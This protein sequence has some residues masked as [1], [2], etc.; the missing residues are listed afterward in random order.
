[1][2]QKT[3]DFKYRITNN[4]EINNLF[5]IELI[6]AYSK[7]N[8]S[9]EYKLEEYVCALIT[10]QINDS[11]NLNILLKTATIDSLNEPRNYWIIKKAFEI[12]A[13]D[14]KETSLK[15]LVAYNLNRVY[16]RAHLDPKGTT[17]ER[18][19]PT[20]GS[21]LQNF[22]LALRDYIPQS[23]FLWFYLQYSLQPIASTDWLAL[24]DTYNLE[25]IKEVRE[26]IFPHFVQEWLHFT[27]E[28]VL[29]C[30]E[31]AK[32]NY[33]NALAACGKLFALHEKGKEIPKQE[34]YLA[35]GFFNHI[36]GQL[37]SR[38]K[39]DKSP[40]HMA[41]LEL[42]QGN[43]EKVIKIL[44]PVVSNPQEV[45]NYTPVE[46]NT[47]YGMLAKSHE[48]IGETD[49]ALV[50]FETVYPRL[51]RSCENHYGQKEVAFDAIVCLK[52]K[53]NATLAQTD[54][55]ENNAN[56]LVFYKRALVREGQK[57]YLEAISLFNK[58]L[59]LYIPKTGL[60]SKECLACYSSLAFSFQKLGNIDTAYLQCN[61]AYALALQLYQKGQVE[62][63]TIEQQFRQL[64]LE[65]NSPIEDVVEALDELRLT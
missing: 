3:E 52:T 65:I 33:P 27:P 61:M 42:R 10:D 55:F 54:F 22:L 30:L 5:P 1:M 13:F 46:W 50:L 24:F 63:D 36:V 57:E 6:D 49:K 19:I 47:V 15:L 16:G 8:P 2:E 59:T 43:F 20:N 34:L 18:Y 25:N 41:M 56:P 37:E 14:G 38:L 32:E 21:L 62:L 12:A 4:E 29:A 45:N 35:N 26:A 48:L 7:P 64:E 17:Y 51:V 58:A 39:E 31:Y 40:F 44:T 53:D 23:P 60:I 28:L 9:E 11:L